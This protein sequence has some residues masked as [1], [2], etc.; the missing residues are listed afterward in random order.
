[1]KVHEFENDLR[2]SEEASCES[3]W[4]AIYEKA[5]PTLVSSMSCP[6]DYESQRQGIDRVVLLSSGQLL[7]IDEKKRRGQW[8]DMLLEYIA[9]DQTN[10]PGWIEKNLAIDYLAYA[11]M[12]TQ[13]CYLFPWPFLQKAWFEN[14][15]R[16]L[17]KYRKVP[18]QN[19]TY[20]TW[21]LAVPINSLYYAV[22]QATRITLDREESPE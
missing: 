17:V 1:M 3:F 18:A 9:N 19:P 21:C 14:K 10:A 12:P 16:W 2:F 7:R 20:K 4:N 13:T 5:F 6:G 22:N 8:N 15:E 11:F